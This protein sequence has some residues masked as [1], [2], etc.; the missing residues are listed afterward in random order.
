MFEFSVMKESKILLR[1]YTI[2]RKV[3]KCFI[4]TEFSSQNLLSIKNPHNFFEANMEI[5][6]KCSN[7]V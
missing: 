7:N 2:A 4:G 6:K 1:D 5:C 3:F